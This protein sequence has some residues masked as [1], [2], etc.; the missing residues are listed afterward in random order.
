MALLQPFS[1]ERQLCLSTSQ[2][3]LW[4][5]A[6]VLSTVQLHSQPS[7]SD[8]FKSRKKPGCLL[9]ATSIYTALQRKRLPIQ[10]EN[11]PAGLSSAQRP[12]QTSEHGPLSV[13][14]SW[15]LLCEHT[16]PSLRNARLPI[17]LLHMGCGGCLRVKLHGGIVMVTWSRG[18]LGNE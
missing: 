14:V 7:V 12:L 13:S 8:P 3:S 15:V 16:S 6:L 1:S 18:L 10:C 11:S 5:R 4:R 2:P 9:P 17:F